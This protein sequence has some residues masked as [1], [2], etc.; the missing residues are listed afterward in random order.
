MSG[1]APNALY[2]NKSGN[3]KLTAS[4]LQRFL[5]VAAGGYDLTIDFGPAFLALSGSMRLLIEVLI[6]AALIC[7][8]W[9]KPYKQYADQTYTKITSIVDGLGGSLQK[10][11]DQSVKRY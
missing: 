10:H 3:T 9:T 5:G 4:T 8:G 7:V 6:I 1:V 2:E 11:Q